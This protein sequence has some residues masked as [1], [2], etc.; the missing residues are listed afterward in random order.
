MHPQGF[1]K[2]VRRLRI[3]RELSQAGLATRA[4]VTREYIARLEAGRH[5][6]QLSTLKRLARALGVSAA[7]L[8]R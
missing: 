5:D 2:H 8:I 4:R 7:E 3:A 6:P 1:G